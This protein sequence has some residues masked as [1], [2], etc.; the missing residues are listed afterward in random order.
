MGIYEGFI[1]TIRCNW[2]CTLSV[3]G[4]IFSLI[5]VNLFS[6]MFEIW[7]SPWSLSLSL[8]LIRCSSDS[9]VASPRYITGPEHTFVAHPHQQVL[10]WADPDG[11]DSADTRCGQQRNSYGCGQYWCFSCSKVFCSSDLQLPAL[12]FLSLGLLLMY[13]LHSCTVF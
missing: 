9:W 5:P 13:A 7:Q 3:S 4:L 6:I 10:G 2:I 1:A 12:V 8:I 11:R